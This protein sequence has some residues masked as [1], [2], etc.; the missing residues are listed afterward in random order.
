MFSLKWS[1]L[2]ELSFGAEELYDEVHGSSIYKHEI[3]WWEEN[4]DDDEEEEEKGL[5]QREVDNSADGDVDGDGDAGD[6][7]VDGSGCGVDGIV[8]DDRSVGDDGRVGDEDISKK[9]L[10]AKH[11][12]NNNIILFSFLCTIF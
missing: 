1:H 4:Y 6:G 2:D 3:T 5:H 8:G 11:I 10:P 12:C 7:G 9:K